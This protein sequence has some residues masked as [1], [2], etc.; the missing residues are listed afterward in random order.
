VEILVSLLITGIIG[1]GIFS[2]NDF[3]LNND[4]KN[5][6]VSTLANF[7]EYIYDIVDSTPIT[8]DFMVA[9]G[10]KF[11]IMHLSNTTSENDDVY[12]YTNNPSFK[13]EDLGFFNFS[14]S[15]MKDYSLEIIFI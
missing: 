14:S 8:D 2:I 5:R 9:T 4:T 11:Y 6:K 7:S 13:T 1:F 15:Q 10:Q 12:V 3:L